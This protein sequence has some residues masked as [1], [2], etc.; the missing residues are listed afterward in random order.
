MNFGTG[1]MKKP[2]YT[3]SPRK[4]NLI[5]AFSTAPL[6]PFFLFW[7]RVLQSQ[8]FKVRLLYKANYASLL[9][10]LNF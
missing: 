7:T 9:N 5:P 2:N 10:K 1:R 8:I 3:G 6:S 4:A